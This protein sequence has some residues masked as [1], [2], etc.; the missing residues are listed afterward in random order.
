MSQP[1]LM[2]GQPLQPAVDGAIHV[3]ILDRREKRRS[4]NRREGEQEQDEFEIFS[5][6]VLF[7]SRYGRFYYSSSISPGT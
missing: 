5:T 3:G 4:R 7:V 6:S 1:R 2:R